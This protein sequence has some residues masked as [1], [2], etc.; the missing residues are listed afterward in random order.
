MLIPIHHSGDLR[1]ATPSPNSPAPCE[2][3]SPFFLKTKLEPINKPLDTANTIP[4]I[5]RLEPTERVLA[6]LEVALALAVVEVALAVVDDAALATAN[7]VGDIGKKNM[8][9]R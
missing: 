8:V 2:R 9:K 3:S 7:R 4:T 5:L 6:E 1:Y